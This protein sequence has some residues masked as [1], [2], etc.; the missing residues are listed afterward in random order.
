[1]DF[2]L[3]QS[4][5]KVALNGRAIRRLAPPKHKSCPPLQVHATE[6]LNDIVQQI[7]GTAKGLTRFFPH[8]WWRG[9]CIWH[10]SQDFLCVE[11]SS[12][13][14]AVEVERASR[15]PYC[16]SH[17]LF[18]GF[19]MFWLSSLFLNISLT[20]AHPHRLL[21]TE[22]PALSVS[23][24]FALPSFNNQDIVARQKLLGWK[25]HV[26]YFTMKDVHKFLKRHLI[27]FCRSVSE[28]WTLGA[29]FYPDETSPK[30]MNNHWSQWSLCKIG[31][32]VF[33][34]TLW[35]LFSVQFL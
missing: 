30:S 10:S 29:A 9:R 25:L 11:K 8:V 3:Q 13:R 32:R 24:G 7:C 21:L 23:L 34:D 35:C 5:Y 12:H 31:L 15:T 4:L 33:Y 27:F 1:M 28:N 26:C 6:A 2:F 16:C 14:S 19:G 17:D 18:K 20:E 22:L